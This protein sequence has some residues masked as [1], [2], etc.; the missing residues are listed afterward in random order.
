MAAPVKPRPWELVDPEHTGVHVP[1]WLRPRDL[2]VEA[3]HLALMRK[4]ER[5][6]LGEAGDDDAE[7]VGDAG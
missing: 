7:H 4:V 6:V 1:Y 2:E 5:A 3:A